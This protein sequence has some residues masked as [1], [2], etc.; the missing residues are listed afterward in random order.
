MTGRGEIIQA[1]AAEAAENL[2]NSEMQ[3]SK[4]PSL[5]AK[6]CANDWPRDP[7]NT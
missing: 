2:E 4:C 7:R 1:E 5:D 6:R 3:L